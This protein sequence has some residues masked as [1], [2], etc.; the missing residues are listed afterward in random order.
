[1][2]LVLMRHSAAAN[3]SPDHG[4]KLAAEGRNQSKERARDLAAYPFDRAIVSDAERAKETYNLLNLDIPEVAYD[5]QIYYGSHQDIVDKVRALPDTV[6]T[7]LIVGHEPTISHSAAIL[8]QSSARVHEVRA[9]VSTATAIVL[10]F[11]SWGGPG[12]I[13]DIHR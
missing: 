4:R 5:P 11:E 8:G 3:G 7:V 6:T 9:G 12:D 10:D 1:M 13:V 2:Q